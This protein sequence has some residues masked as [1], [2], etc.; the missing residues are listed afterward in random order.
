MDPVEIYISCRKCKKDFVIKNL[1]KHAEKNRD[2]NQ[3]YTQDQISD[4][5]DLSKEVSKAKKRIKDAERYL[6][7]KEE[8]AEKYQQKKAQIAEKNKEKKEQIA[9]KYQEKK[10]QIA[11]KRRENYDK[12]KRRDDYQKKKMEIAETYRRHRVLLA[13]RYF[14]IDM[15]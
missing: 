5:K 1:A 11:E 15:A 12:A 3:T 9:E 6:K 2:C 4:L 13:I 10:E 7:K 14:R 8:L